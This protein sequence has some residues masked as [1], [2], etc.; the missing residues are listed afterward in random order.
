[1]ARLQTEEFGKKYP[2]VWPCLCWEEKSWNT[3]NDRL[4]N[5]SSMFKNY[6]FPI[7]KHHSQS[8]REFQGNNS[9]IATFS[10][11][12]FS[13]HLYSSV[14][15]S[16]EMGKTREMSEEEISEVREYRYVS[17]ATVGESFFVFKKF[18]FCLLLKNL[19]FL[20]KLWS[21]LIN[22]LLQFLGN[23]RFYGQFVS[24]KEIR[25]R[26]VALSRYCI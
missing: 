26:K 23:V 9:I 15:C 20:Q 18:C 2:I 16:W 24:L 21:F 10:L 19:S 13:M 22:S 4:S 11:L 7:S 25:S 5:A 14:L 8:V 6:T 17:F 3:E 1:M 12:N